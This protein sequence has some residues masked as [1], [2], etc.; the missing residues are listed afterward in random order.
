MK[1]G[2]ARAVGAAARVGLAGWID[3][4]VSIPSPLYSGE[5]VRVRG[6]FSSAGK[7]LTPRPLPRVQGR[8]GKAYAFCGDP[9]KLYRTK[10]PSSPAGSFAGFLRART[11]ARYSA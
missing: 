11:V 3:I 9:R 1:S 8:G 2:L 5:R 6:S 4:L 7:P 10:S